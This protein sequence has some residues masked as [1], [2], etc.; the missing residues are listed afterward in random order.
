VRLIVQ[1]L[2]HFVVSGPFLKAMI[3]T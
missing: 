2:L 3:I 1:W